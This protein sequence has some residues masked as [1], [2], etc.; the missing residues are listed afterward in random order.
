METFE[1]R[2]A[3]YSIPELNDWVAKFKQG[4]DN[5]ER[6]DNYYYTNGKRTA[7][8]ATLKRIT[9]RIEELENG[10]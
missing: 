7:A 4:M 10:R 6:S 2:L 8:L 1:D 9:D 5:A 3:T